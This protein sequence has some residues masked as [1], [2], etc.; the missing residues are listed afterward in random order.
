M[1]DLSLVPNETSIL[2]QRKIEGRVAGV[3]RAAGID[4]VSAPVASLELGYDGIPGDY[5]HGLARKSG[6]R[7]PWYPRGTEMR[8]NRQVSIVSPV[9]IAE[10]AAAMGLDRIE[11]EWIGANIVLEGVP[12]LSMLPS[13]TLLFFAGGVTLKV[14]GQ[15]HL[16]R[17]AGGA[18]AANF[19]DR[20]ATSLALSFKDAAK[21]RR[22]LVAWVE[23]TGR[24]EAGEAVTVRI[25]EQWLYT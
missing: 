6:G 19:P 23:K 11:P 1:D 15:N 22:G 20:D 10:A 12:R 3:Y 2:P 24:I 25:P 9:E 18:I 8:N 13:G 5:H 17:L 7:E 4:F 21:R 16:C 14:D